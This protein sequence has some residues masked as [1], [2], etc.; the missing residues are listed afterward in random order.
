M[1]SSVRIII[2]KYTLGIKSIIIIILDLI[3]GGMGEGTFHST[4]FS[5]NSDKK[6]KETA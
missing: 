4:S 6:K 2:Y 1:A 5:G 3:L